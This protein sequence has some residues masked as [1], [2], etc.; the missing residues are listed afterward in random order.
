LPDG[1]AIVAVTVMSFTATATNLTS[2]TYAWNLGDGSSASGPTVT[3]VY[4]AEGT[5]TAT[6]TATGAEGAVNASASVSARSVTGI[7]VEVGAVNRD[8]FVIELRQ[9]G[10]VVTGQYT[11]SPGYSNELSGTL[12]DDREL[13]ILESG[14]CQNAI[15]G[16]FSATLMALEGEECHAGSCPDPGCRHVSYARQ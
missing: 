15:T 7:W 5:F 9:E 12:A 13:S 6:V 10:T 2:P 11:Q 14:V 1:T 16:E 4:A 8:P 3:H